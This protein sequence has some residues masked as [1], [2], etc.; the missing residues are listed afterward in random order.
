MVTLMTAML[1]AWILVLGSGV[2][3]R[4]WTFPECLTGSI[5]GASFSLSVSLHPSQPL[6][7]QMSLEMNK[8]LEGLI[9]LYS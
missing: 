7:E 8:H 3:A 9:Q 1:W 4:K 6:Q 2:K 5:P